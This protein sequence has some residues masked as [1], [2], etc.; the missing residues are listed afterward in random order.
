MGNEVKECKNPYWNQYVAPWGWHF[1]Y[2][3]QNQ[4]RIIWRNNVDGYTIEKD[5]TNTDEN[6]E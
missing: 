4:G 3:G 5:E 2:D 1:V 6:S